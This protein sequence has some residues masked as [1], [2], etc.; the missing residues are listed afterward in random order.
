MNLINSLT[1]I[2]YDVIIFHKYLYGK[3]DLYR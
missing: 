1:Y 2:E 3:D